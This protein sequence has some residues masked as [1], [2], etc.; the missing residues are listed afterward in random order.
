MSLKLI[1]LNYLKK[2]YPRVIHQGEIERKTLNEWGYEASNASRR[3]RELR[4][5]GLIKRILNEKGEAQYQYAET[6]SPE[7]KEETREVKKEIK[8]LTF[9]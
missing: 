4:E 5:V 3:C 8:Q 2:E 1:I 6:N 9:I 7:I